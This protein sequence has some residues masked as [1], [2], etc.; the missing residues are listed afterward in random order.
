MST[1]HCVGIGGV[2]FYGIQ[3]YGNYLVCESAAQPHDVGRQFVRG[4][5]WGTLFNGTTLYVASELG[6]TVIPNVDTSQQ[7]CCPPRG[8][9]MRLDDST[10]ACP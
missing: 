2:D 9:I 1:R 4:N 3:T 10:G 8:C 7:R 5:S 6:L